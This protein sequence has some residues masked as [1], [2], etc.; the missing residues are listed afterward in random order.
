MAK[1][2]TSSRYLPLTNHPTSGGILPVTQRSALIPSLLVRIEPL[3]NEYFVQGCVS[4]AID[5]RK[6]SISAYIEPGQTIVCAFQFPDG[7]KPRQVETFQTIA[8]TQKPFQPCDARHFDFRQRI[9]A[10]LHP[11]KSRAGTHIE[12]FEPIPGALQVA[13]RRGEYQV[14]QRI[15]LAFQVFE[16][17]S[18]QVELS[19][20]PVA[21]TT[22]INQ[23]TVCRKVEFGQ[24][25]VVAPQGIQPH[26]LAHIQVLDRILR[27]TETAQLRI[28]CYI[29]GGHR[30]VVLHMQAPERTVGPDVQLR[31]NPAAQVHLL[32]SGIA[33]EVERRDPGKGALQV[34]QGR[35]ARQ[36]E[37][38]KRIA[39]A[40]EIFQM[41]IFRHVERGISV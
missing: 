31:E 39:P 33:R 23:R 35:I 11:R 12:H 2:G 40:T 5:R 17:R 20:D 16:P 36:I 32:Q 13:R 15:V 29:E 26:A 28:L 34:L 1:S 9:A 22:Q 3:P 41:R 10:A 21:R 25:I 24:A 14:V 27:R 38:D 37:R 30:R 19:G 18:G 6:R 7:G 8:G 4:S